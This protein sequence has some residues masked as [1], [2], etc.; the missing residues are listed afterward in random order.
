MQFNQIDSDELLRHQM[1]EIQRQYLE[2]QE[3]EKVD[4]MS[5]IEEFDR[6]KRPQ[7]QMDEATSK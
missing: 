2:D 1:L 3:T 6:Q 5:V 7:E 4:V